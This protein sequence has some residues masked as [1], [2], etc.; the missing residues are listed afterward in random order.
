MELIR[1]DKDEL[2][3]KLTENKAK[4]REVLEEAIEGFRTDALAR[5][6]EQIAQIER[7]SVREVHIRIPRLSDHTRDYDRVIA[8][9][10][11]SQDD[12]IMLSETDFA[13]YVMDDWAWKRE[14]IVGNKMYSKTAETM[15][16]AYE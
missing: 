6:E 16:A 5:L 1:V 14:F 11:M 7:G 2:I 15:S 3:A 8:M 12:E 4:H 9:L 13:S 10:E